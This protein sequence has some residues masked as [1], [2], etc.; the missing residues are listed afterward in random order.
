MFLCLFGWPKLI[1][2]II[3]LNLILDKNPAQTQ[4]KCYSPS[5][6]SNCFI[7]LDYFLIA[8]LLEYRWEQQVQVLPDRSILISCQHGP[9]VGVEVHWQKSLLLG[10]GQSLV[11]FRPSTDWMKPTHCMEDNLL[12]S[13]ST[14]LHVNLIQN[15]PQR[16]ITFLYPPN[17]KLYLFTLIK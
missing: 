9:P 5:I 2:L 6:V 1:G 3:V 11:L 14:N 7:S 13:K 17:A 8:V 12:Y 15:I 16:N 10:G 4:C